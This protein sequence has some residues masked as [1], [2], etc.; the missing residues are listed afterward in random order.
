LKRCA[1]IVNPLAANGLA[2]Q[3]WRESLAQHVKD[4]LAQAGWQLEECSSTGPGGTRAAAAQACEAGVGVL[5]VVGGDGTVH[6]VVSGLMAARQQHG[7]QR[8][9]AL[10]M[11]PLGTGSDYARTFGW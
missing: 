9:P 8:Q 5:L 10:V 1:A 6:E 7:E 11:L 4:R 3:L 2:A